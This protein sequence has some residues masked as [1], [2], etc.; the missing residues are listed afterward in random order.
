MKSV[1]QNKKITC[2]FQFVTSA[3]MDYVQNVVLRNL[4]SVWP[5]N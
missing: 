2:H 3:C 4:V 5:D 1:F